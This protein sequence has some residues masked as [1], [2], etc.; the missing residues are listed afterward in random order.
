MKKT[1]IIEN[2]L[3]GSLLLIYLIWAAAF[4]YQ[5]SFIAIDGKRY[6][7]LVDDAMI[8]MRY[9]WNF[10]HGYGLVWNAGER[11]EGYTNLFMVLVM[12]LATLIFN[13]VN[14]VLAIQILGIPVMLGDAFLTRMIA[15]RLTFGRPYQSLVSKF[16]MFCV[17]FYFPLNYW[18]LMGMET[19]VLTLFLLASIYSALEWIAKTRFSHL[20][21]MSVC[22]GLAFLTRNDSA[23]LVTLIFLYVLV[24]TLLKRERKSSLFFLCIAGIIFLLFIAGQ[25]FLRRYYYGEWLPNTYYLKLYKFPL[26]VRIPDG[27]RYVWPFIL[28]SILPIS[29]AGLSFFFEE[30]RKKVFLFSFLI[31]VLGY[32]IWV[33]GDPWVYW[34]MMCPAMPLLFILTVWTTQDLATRFGNHVT[35]KKVHPLAGLSLVILCLF[36]ANLPFWPDIKVIATSYTAELNKHNMDVAI[37]LNEL[38]THDATI[39]VVEAGLIP[40]YLDRYAIDFLGKSDKHIARLSPDISGAISWSGMISVPGHNK[41]DLNYSIK[42]LKPTYIQVAYW[43]KQNLLG[44]VQ[45]HYVRVEYSGVNGAITVRLLSGAP[46]VLWDKGTILTSG[47][48]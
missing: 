35:P 9:A 26:H 32:Q 36:L 34:R 22:G 2:L 19:A 15:E 44:W 37:A 45:E 11:V 7:S 17:L 31:A 38:T 42:Q 28:Q 48:N 47:G 18:S 39:G 10:S 20:V 43:G 3:I 23:I 6:F 40:Y 33:G 24:E 29:I 14:A 5:S 4:I 27:I 1:R 8:S 21:I 46:S 16:S 25:L 13:K 30:K 41:Y 12:S